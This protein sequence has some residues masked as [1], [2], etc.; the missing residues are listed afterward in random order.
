MNTSLQIS[1]WVVAHEDQI[2]AFLSHLA[3]PPT[4]DE[5]EWVAEPEALHIL[6]LKKTERLRLLAVWGKVDYQKLD[7]DL[8]LYRK[9]SLLDYLHTKTEERHG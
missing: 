4:A 7:P 6:S 8:W 2:I 1:K 3:G 5:D 9:G